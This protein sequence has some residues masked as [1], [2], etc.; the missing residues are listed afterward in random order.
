MSG[1]QH[2]RRA[3]NNHVLSRPRGLW[4]RILFPVLRTAYTQGYEAGYATGFVT[5]DRIARDETGGVVGQ[6]G[7]TDANA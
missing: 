3:L 6:E 4:E 2:M 5:A 1:H 7:E